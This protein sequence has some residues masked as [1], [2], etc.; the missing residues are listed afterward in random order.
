LTITVIPCPDADHRNSQTPPHLACKFAGNMLEHHG[1][2]SSRLQLRSLPQQAFLAAW[3]LRLTAVAKAVD[4]LRQQSQMPHHR[5]PR[6]NQAFNHRQDLR[7]GTL[8]LH[9]SRIGLFDQSSCCGHRAIQAALVA[10]KGEVR[11]HQRLFG[12]R[13]AQAS[14]DRLGVQHHLLQCDWKGCAV[15]EADHG[16]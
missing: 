11:D 8:K 1:K 12:Q 13:F 6:A 5:D 10:E 3:I 15:A 4:R 9:P 16:E 14:T 2:A 7:F